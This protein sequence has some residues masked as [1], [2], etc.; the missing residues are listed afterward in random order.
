MGKGRTME[1]EKRTPA[2][3]QVKEQ[4]AKLETV[5]EKTKKDPAGDH[6]GEDPRKVI[7]Y[8]D[9]DVDKIV[10]K[11]IMRERERLQ[12]IMDENVHETELEERER[13]ILA[14]E[15]RADAV[16][17]LTEM[18]YSKALADLIDYKDQKTMEASIEKV[19]EIVGSVIKEAILK[20]DQQR[21]KGRTPMNYSDGERP[22][23]LREAF[24]L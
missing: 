11:K 1:N 3:D 13:K 15:L 17:R 5:S 19:T 16:E 4:D 24:K 9:E 7:K 12:Q 22:D 2:A 23:R 14:R 20:N 6:T 8:S 10:H 21:A 18:G